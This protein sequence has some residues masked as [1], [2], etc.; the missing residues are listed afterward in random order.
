MWTPI[1]LLCLTTNLTEC[2]AIGGPIAFDEESC[3]ESV[4]EVGLP[5][6][7]QK[8]TDKVIHGYQCIQWNQD[9]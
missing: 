4:K 6:L 9:T 2:I 7:K 8:H 1:V 3:I 5:Y